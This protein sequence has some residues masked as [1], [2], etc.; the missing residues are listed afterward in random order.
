MTQIQIGLLSGDL[1]TTHK[2]TFIPPRLMPGYRG[3]CPSEKFDYGQTYGAYTCKRF[4]DYRSTV[5]QSSKTP[6]KNE[7]SFASFYSNDPENLLYNRIKDRGRYDGRFYCQLYNK[8]DRRSNEIG[9]FELQTN[10]VGFYNLLL[11]CGCEF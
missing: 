2:A 5:L 8:D 1:K 6:Y 4:Q 7:G 3:H 11:L 9:N 10:S